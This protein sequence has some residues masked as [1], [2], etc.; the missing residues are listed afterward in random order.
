MTMA[1]E[2]G[3]ALVPKFPHL[4]CMRLEFGLDPVNHS[5]IRSR[6]KWRHPVDS[7]SLFHSL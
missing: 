6:R 3:T 4:A 2:F 1:I 5:R 7:P